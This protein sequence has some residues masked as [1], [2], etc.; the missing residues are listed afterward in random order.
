MSRIG[1]KPVAIPAGVQVDAKPGKIDVKGPKGSLSLDVHPAITVDVTEK[2]IVV[3]RQTDQRQHRALHGLVRSL[4]ANMVI[5][6]SQG[7][8]KKLELHGIGYNVRLDGKNF[9]LQVGY[10]HPVKM[11]IPDGITVEI[12][13]QA[14][15][16]RFT[17]S[18]ADKQAV[19][20]F[21]AE[22]RKVFPPEPYKGKGI[23]YS[24]EIVR[25]KAGKAFA[26]AGGK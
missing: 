19:G 14:N 15:P 17:I 20:Q 4:I 1:K 10:C 5:G 6:V 11:A 12:Q 2:E 3:G 7:F 21:S 13:N 23:R 22:V 16:G 24:D 18:G 25:R 9:V 26:A 8:T